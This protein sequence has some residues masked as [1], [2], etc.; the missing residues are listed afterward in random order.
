MHDVEDLFHLLPD[1]FPGLAQN[2]RTRDVGLVSFAIT[3]I[4]NDYKRPFANYLRG[5]RAVRK[6]GVFTDLHA[7][8]AREAKLSV[9]RGNQFSYLMLSHAFAQCMIN[10]FICG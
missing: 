4:V 8:L 5:P 6:R 1:I 9:S 2:E 10:R 3:A 7:G